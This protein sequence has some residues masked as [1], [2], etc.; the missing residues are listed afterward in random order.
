MT[1]FKR[2]PLNFLKN[3]GYAIGSP[4]VLYFAVYFI[5]G[6]FTEDTKMLSLIGYGLGVLSFLYLLHSVLFSENIHVEI[7][8]KELRYFKRGHLKERYPF[9][10]YSFGYRT[11]T[12]GS[13]T[14]TINLQI[15]ELATETESTLDLQPL[16]PFQ[17]NKLFALIEEYQANLTQAEELV[18]K[19]K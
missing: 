16:G 4:V 15:F 3:F 6:F 5:G 14:D 10:E 11:V 2:T 18:A 17:F 13:T 7:D 12:S 19:E 8:E 1:T 9:T